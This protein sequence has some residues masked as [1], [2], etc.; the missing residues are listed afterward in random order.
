[1]VIGIRKSRF[2]TELKLQVAFS[3]LKK[4]DTELYTVDLFGQR[5]TSTNYSGLILPLLCTNIAPFSR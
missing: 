1:V 3:T 4:I 2:K 5:N